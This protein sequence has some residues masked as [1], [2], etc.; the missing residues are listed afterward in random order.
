[1]YFKE[2]AVRRLCA[3]PGTYAPRST[4]HGIPKCPIWFVFHSAR[5]IVHQRVGSFAPPRNGKPRVTGGRKA[6]GTRTSRPGYRR[7]T[8]VK[9]LVAVIGMVGTLVSFAGPAGAANGG[10]AISTRKAVG[11]F[12]DNGPTRAIS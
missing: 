12:G 2:G 9:K 8:V 4:P 5:R 3:Y 7:E 11:P 1:M 10:Q 6:N